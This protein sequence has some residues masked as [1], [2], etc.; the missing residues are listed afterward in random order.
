MQN[1]STFQTVLYFFS[2]NKTDLLIRIQRTLKKKTSYNVRSN[3]YQN[4][5]CTDSA[6]CFFF[7][8][9]G[10]ITELFNFI[11]FLERYSKAWLDEFAAGVI[12]VPT[13]VFRQQTFGITMTIL[14][15]NTGFCVSATLC[16]VEHTTIQ[17]RIGVIIFNIVFSANF[18]GSC[19]AST[20]NDQRRKD[21][22]HPTYMHITQ[23]V[24]RF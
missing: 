8:E 13:S 21:Q 5:I 10:I 7:S 20:Q 15:H 23:R 24:V 12:N 17:F 2:K 22:P 19:S 16:F 18:S 9:L 11:V 1:R 6:C 3:K 4:K 14:Y